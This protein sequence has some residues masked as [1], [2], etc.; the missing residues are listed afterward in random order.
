M[1][2]ERN[3]KKKP[4]NKLPINDIAVLGLVTSRSY[5]GFTKGITGKQLI[6]E[7]KKANFPDWVDIKYS[8][9]Y[10][11]L[12]RLEEYKY[13]KSK[14]DIDN[15]S[16]KRIKLYQITK[17]GK[18]ALVSNITFFLSTP[19]KVKSPLDIA[20]GNLG[21][22]PRDISVQA[23]KSYLNKLDQNIKYL[24]KYVNGLKNGIPGDIVGH[25]TLFESMMPVVNNIIA[26]FERPYRELIAR[27][28]WLEDFIQKLEEGKI[29]TGDNL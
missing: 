22:L 16:R 11:C 3:L 2:K 9:I 20:I 4:P 25:I 23:L 7:M 12:S 26:L 13:L 17:S 8:T 18:K 19:I 15:E 5:M 1:S 10:N 14:N 29:F 24:E 21:L 27:K 6:N 28:N